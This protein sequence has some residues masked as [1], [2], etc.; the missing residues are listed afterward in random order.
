M[1]H[2]QFYGTVWWHLIHG[3]IRV[4]GYMVVL[5]VGG[6]L[7]GGHVCH[8]CGFKSSERRILHHHLVTRHKLEEYKVSCP[9]CQRSFTRS[10]AMRR[11]YK[12]THSD[13]GTNQT[14]TQDTLIGVP[15]NFMNF[16][17]QTVIAYDGIKL[18]MLVLSEYRIIQCIHRLMLSSWHS[19]ST[20][21]LELSFIV[22]GILFENK[23]NIF[24]TSVLITIALEL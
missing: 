22:D 7:S 18:Q 4:T 24:A 10:D 13:T 5:Q 1:I 8:V 6:S 23:R 12:Q 19:R 21:F 2:E 9:I 3:S 15:M 16:P 17:W 14:L 20:C 11:H